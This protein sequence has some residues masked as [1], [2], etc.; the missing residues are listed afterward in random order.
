MYPVAERL[1]A[2]FADSFGETADRPEHAHNAPLIRLAH[3]ARL[4]KD[5]FRDPDLDPLLAERWAGRRRTLSVVSADIRKVRQSR[6][7]DGS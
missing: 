7:R 2:R 5:F 1:Q 6:R 3:F 4:H